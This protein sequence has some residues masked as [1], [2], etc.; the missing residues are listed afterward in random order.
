MKTGIAFPYDILLK[1]DDIA[2]RMGIPN[3]SKA[4]VEAAMKFISDNI[5]VYGNGFIVGAL[6][7][8][9][10]DSDKS[11]QMKMLEI[12]NKFSYSINATVKIALDNDKLMDIWLV[13]GDVRTIKKLIESLERLNGVHVLRSILML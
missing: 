11:I 13:R 6:S 2:R 5:W 7:I 9:H 3:R 8:V 10:R 1:F 12:R 4:V